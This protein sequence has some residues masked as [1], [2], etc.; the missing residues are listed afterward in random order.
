M[1]NLDTVCTIKCAI[2]RPSSLFDNQAPL[3]CFTCQNTY[4]VHDGEM[5]KIF[6][7]HRC[8]PHCLP[9]VHMSAFSSGG[10][11]GVS[12]PANIQTVISTPGERT[13]I[14]FVGDDDFNRKVL[15]CPVCI[16]GPES[17]MTSKKC[18][19]WLMQELPPLVIAPNRSV[20]VD[21]NGKSFNYH[22][23]YGN[24]S[25]GLGGSI[26]YVNCDLLEYEFPDSP[27]L[28]GTVHLITDSYVGMTSCQVR[29]QPHTAT[30]VDGEACSLNQ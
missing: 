21:C 14:C 2:N 13:R 12:S 9:L 10:C 25:V 6:V 7:A 20:T 18:R 17:A 8:N 19:P 15:S 26:E 28:Y 1:W 24:L 30:R 22:S 29:L 3:S 23:K 27:S 11:T 4:A 16:L 5:G